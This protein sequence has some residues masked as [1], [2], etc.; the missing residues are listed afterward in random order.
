V[1]RAD[2]FTGRVIVRGLSATN[3]PGS[4]PLPDFVELREL[5]ADVNV[6][7]WIFSGRIVVNE[8]DV[9]LGRSSSSAA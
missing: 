4:Y 3:P 7:S 6:F 9:D 5:R 8:L 1:L 2:P